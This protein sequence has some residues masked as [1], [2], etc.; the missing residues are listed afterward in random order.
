MRLYMQCPICDTTKKERIIQLRETITDWIYAEPLQQLI[1]LYNG[2]IPENYSFSEYIDWLKQFAERWDYRKKQANGGERWKI[3][4]AEME[5]IHGKKIM[6]AA[7]GLGM[8]DRTEITM[9]PDYILPLGGARAAN[10]DRVQMTKK[11]IDSLL[12]AN[13]KIVAL[14]GFRE[15]NEIER[16]YTDPYAPNAKTEFDVMNASLEDEF[17]LN[18]FYQDEDLT[19]TNIFLQSAIR[20]YDDTYNQCKVYSIAAPS[21]DLTRRA[22]S[23]DT[24]EFFMKKFRVHEKAK[25][26]LI[27]SCIYVPFQLMKFMELAIKKNIQVDCIGVD[28]SIGGKSSLQAVNYLQEIKGTID[29][30]WKLKELYFA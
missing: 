8:C 15:I 19:N 22:N 2:K 11:L 7:K 16:E 21:S 20:K 27:T 18:T 1:E 26:L 13:K 6:E 14:T 9:V 23:M 17:A 12:L 4:N 5:V 28:L 25:I 29:A 3:S 24:F 10:H 30:I